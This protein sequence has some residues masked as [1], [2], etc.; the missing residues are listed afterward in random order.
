MAENHVV[1]AAEAGGT[2]FSDSLAG[3]V[4]RKK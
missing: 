2:A 3:Q 1:R 4:L